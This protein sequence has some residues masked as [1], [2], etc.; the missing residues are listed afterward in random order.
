MRGAL[1]IEELERVAAPFEEASP[2]PSR[3]YF[4][5]EQFERERRA[6]F[7]RAHVCVGREDEVAAPS[8]WILAEVSGEGVVVARGE[9]LE[10]R[11]FK[12]VCRHRGAELVA[13]HA[14][15]ARCFTC[16]YH[17]WT[18][19]LDGALRDAPFAP[20]GFDR[21]AHGLHPLRVEVWQGFVFVNAD[22]RAPSLVG[23]FGEAPPWLVAR[24]VS[25]LRRAHRT[26]WEVAANWKL[27]VENFQESHHFPRVH[28]ALE[29]L[30]PTRS[31]RSWLG[32]GRWL[33]GTMEI[34]DAETVSTSGRRRGRPLL[35]SAAEARR[36][37]D[38]MLFPLLLTSLQPDYLLTYRLEPR[39]VD[40]TRVVADVLVHPEASAEHLGEITDFWAQVNVEDRAIC[41]RQQRGLRGRGVEAACY[42]TVEEGVHAFD[43]L[44]AR[45]L[46]EAR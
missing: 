6:I 16:P 45:A 42:A 13:G 36:V 22:P 30:T 46:L 32:R 12:N 27:V 20:A 8:A 7:E 2:F 1:T 14:G 44:V 41:E 26:A 15:Q 19:T 25:S 38:A 10:L 11:A 5:D 17:G 35:V 21:G 9:D 43:R 29:A 24:D 34:E 33:G 18:Y 28:P 23:S 3:A 31:A 39:A 4:D 40:R 37:H